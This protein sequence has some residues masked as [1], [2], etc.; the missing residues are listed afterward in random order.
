MRGRFR[1]GPDRDL[2]NITVD[3]NRGPIV[4]GKATTIHAIKRVRHSGRRT[5]SPRL[6]P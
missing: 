1:G 5:R 2:M 4:V 3:Q 6:L